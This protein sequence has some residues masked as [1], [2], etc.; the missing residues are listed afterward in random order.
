MKSTTELEEKVRGADAEKEVRQAQ[1]GE[2]TA[3]AQ[4]AS[5]DLKEK[6]NVMA[7]NQL[8]C[9]GADDQLTRAR[10]AQA[11]TM[12]DLGEAAGKKQEL[13]EATANLYTPLQAGT[14]SD[15]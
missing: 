12:Q 9:K 7:N 13:T 14:V 8:A 11:K 10:A 6:Q 4:R 1:L 5:Q 3:T 15:P 2:A